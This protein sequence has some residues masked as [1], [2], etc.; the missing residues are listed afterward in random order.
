[1][2]TVAVEAHPID[3]NLNDPAPISILTLQDVSGLIEQLAETAGSLTG[4]LEEL[5][6]ARAKLNH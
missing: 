1:M 6:H 5:R 2:T 4:T 3:A